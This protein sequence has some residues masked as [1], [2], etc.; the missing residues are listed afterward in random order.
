MGRVHVVGAGLAGLA[1]AVRLVGAGRAVTLYEAAGQAGGR[2]RS[3]FDDVIGHTIDN[4]NHLMLSANAAT[5]SY[6]D[7][8]GAGDSLTGPPGAEFPFVDLRSGTRWT[9]RP[10][11]GPLPWWIFAPSRRVPDT[12]PW[13][14]V[15][16]LGVVLAGREDTVADRIR[17][18][19]AMFER[20]WEPLAV[21]VLNAAPAEG[22]ARLLR[23][24]LLQ[25]F[26]RGAA[27]CRPLVA[28]DGLSASFVQPALD[29]LAAAGAD[30]RFNHRLRALE[31][32]PDG[33]DALAFGRMRAALEAGDRVVLA[34]PPAAAG[35]LVPELTVPLASRAI[36]NGHIRLP[37]PAA[38]DIANPLLGLI[39]GTADWLFLRGE[40]ASLTVSAADALADVPTP[41]IARRFWAD[42]A[43]A[44][45]LDVTHRPPI[46]VIKERRATFAQTPAEVRRRPPARTA[47]PNLMLAGDWI[48]TGFPAT[49]EG[50]IRSGNDAARLAMAA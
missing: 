46:R 8:I 15:A 6:L 42:T 30:I 21:A 28:R 17:A 10:N 3:Y 11:R 2:C 24:M 18:D 37:R 25:T 7:E 22:S 12:G 38:A 49:I 5:L 35:G 33:V 16:S 45:G 27:Y 4:G 41:E 31:I 26:A 39:G 48:D 23:A 14:Y 34:V 47:W 50:A 43:A 1:C 20:F 40:I 29:R 44:L 19:G 36:V 9:L 32:G 13:D